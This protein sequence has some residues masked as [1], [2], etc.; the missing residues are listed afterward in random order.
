[1]KNIKI[2]SAIAII[3][4]VFTMTA[5]ENGKDENRV[6][7]KEPGKTITI[8]D[9][10][11]KDESDPSLSVEKIERIEKVDI[12]DW[13]NEDTVIVSKDNELLDKLSLAELSEYYPKSLYLYNITT[14]EY[15]LIKEQKEVFL[16]GANLSIDK[17]YLIYYEYSL[18]DPVYK[19]MNMDNL[20]VFQISGEP[21]GGAI[22]AKWADN[23]T[24]IGVA[25]SGG[26]YLAERTGK[27]TAI[28]GLEDEA[29]YLIEKINGSIYYNTMYDQNLMKLNLDT[30]EKVSLNIDQVDDII[31]SPDGNQI[32]VLQTKGTKKNMIISDLD[33]GNQLIV[34]DGA[35]ING[36]SWSPD[37]R[38][39]AYNL[40]ADKNSSTISNLYVYDTLTGESIQIA[41]TNEYLSTSWS[42][43]GDKLAYTEGDET[44]YNS[45]I[46]YLEYKQDN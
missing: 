41:V 14:K 3:T 39:I 28:D 32:L 25:Y 38:M 30:K 20:E 22:S 9:D 34:A 40:K 19:V 12:T 36:V 26:G 1:M 2:L 43:S 13:L 15:E 24:I 45:S 7:I 8:I 23:D 29:L 46:V 10:Q 37:Q 4:L 21:I 33:G 31:P 42:P 27:I 5:C 6:T 16:G 35:E 44:G 11:D 18:G 17:K